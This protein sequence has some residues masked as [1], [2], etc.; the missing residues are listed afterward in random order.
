MFIFVTSVGLNN[1]LMLEILSVELMN[2]W[3]QKLSMDKVIIQR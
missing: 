3:R 1:F 2:L